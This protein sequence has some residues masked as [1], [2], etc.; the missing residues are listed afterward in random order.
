MVD[1]EGSTFDN[2]E[3]ADMEMKR[4]DLGMPVNRA[5][6]GDASGEGCGGPGRG[7]GCEWR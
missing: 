7:G 3:M 5:G 2:E 1:E 4:V 6:S